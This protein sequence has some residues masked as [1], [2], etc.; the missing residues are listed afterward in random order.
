MRST[1]PAPASRP[2]GPARISRPL[3]VLAAGGLALGLA[4]AVPAAATPPAG[5][6]VVPAASVDP[7]VPGP[8]GVATFDYD[9]GQTVLTDGAVGAAYPSE[10]TGNVHVPDGPGPYPV[11]VF[12][13]GRH[14]TCDLLVT[15]FLGYPCP[16]TGATGPIPS[17]VG[18][19]Y[20]GELLASHGYVVASINANAVNTFDSTGTRGA[21]ERSQL[22]SRTLDLLASRNAS[23]G[24]DVGD[25]LVGKVDLTRGIGLMGHSR[26]GEGVTRWITYNEERTDGPQYPLAAVFSLAPVDFSR[27]PSDG[28]AF[29]MLLPTCDGDVSNLQG[30]RAFDRGRYVEPTAPRVQ[31]A[32]RGANHNFY[33]TVWTDD[34]NARSDDAACTLGET[35]PEGSV[36]LVPEDERRTGTALITSFLRRYV[37]GE[38]AFD[39]LVRGD[40]ALPASACPTASPA[41]C[42]DL[43][44]TS[45]L[46]GLSDRT[47]LVRP[48]LGSDG[49]T[50]VQGLP[51]STTGALTRTV[52]TGFTTGAD[53][54]PTTPNASA[55]RQLTLAWTGAGALRV[56]LPD[57]FSLGADDVLS[58]RL[59]VNSS[60]PANDGLAEQALDLAVVDGAGREAVVALDG[61]DEPALVP[62][63]GEEESEVLLNGVRV[64]VAELSGVDLTDVVALE[65][66]SGRTTTGSVQVAD[67]T[68]DRSAAGAD[69]P[70]PVV[71]EVPY[72]AL[73]LGLGVLVAVAAGR[74]A[75]APLATRS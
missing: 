27:Y 57:G 18:Y 48:E 72:P 32:V 52:C 42:D 43:V 63:A 41:G 10:L 3:A 22:I 14:A 15:E 33:N 19:D 7:A 68:V 8:L 54:C 61:R 30:A 35:P 26:G 49:S 64:P 47:D 20:L 21:N 44:G 4:T 55:A 65:L 36:R 9:G 5:S 74:R 62:Y 2:S 58:V 51:L 60:V 71:P 50:T 16:E 75:R 69:E 45:Y 13:H 29:A 70:K 28:P 31:Y 24:G 67:L 40:E 25:A 73:A 66:R 38:T 56:P 12:L 59:G 23:A 11:V 17:W 46:P 6:T 53:A 1:P 34:D 37:G 39:A